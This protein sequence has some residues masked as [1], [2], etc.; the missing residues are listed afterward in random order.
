MS[1]KNRIRLVTFEGCPNAEKA[2]SILR[3]LGH[4]F[5][6][7]VQNKL[8]KDDPNRGYS[9]PSILVDGHLVFGAAIDRASSSCTFGVISK[10]EIVVALKRALQ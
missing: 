8:P 2:R 1:V 7:I 9:S 6:E 5:D 4:S 10:A 3:E